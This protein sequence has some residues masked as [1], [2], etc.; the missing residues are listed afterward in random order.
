MLPAKLLLRLHSEIQNNRQMIS[1]KK[2]NQ[3]D[4]ESLEK[5]LKQTK[6]A[7]S[8]LEKKNNKATV[9]YS[10]S[11]K[12]LEL[13]NEKVNE[14]DITKFGNKI[15]QLMESLIN[16]SDQRGIKE[17]MAECN[18]PDIENC[19]KSLSKLKQ[20][21]EKEILQ[22]NREY[23]EVEQKIKNFWGWHGEHKDY[24]SDDLEKLKDRKKTYLWYLASIENDLAEINHLKQ[25]PGELHG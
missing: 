22:L 6:S 8:S 19:I 23:L 4:V 10:R 25:S 21:K 24:Y 18:V 9:N 15:N 17:I 7:I 16:I 14:D 3:L 13:L 2:E 11:E 12:Q 1:E 5:L 20:D